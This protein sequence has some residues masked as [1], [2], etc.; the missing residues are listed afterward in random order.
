[1]DFLRDGEKWGKKVLKVL[2]FKKKSYIFFLPYPNL[3]QLLNKMHESIK[4]SKKNGEK[5]RK[6]VLK[7][8]N[9]VKK[10]PKKG[11]VL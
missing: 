2:N 9:F 6:K 1:V 3:K 5:R 7:V 4:K 8:L 10:S 11:T